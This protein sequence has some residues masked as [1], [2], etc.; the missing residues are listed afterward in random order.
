MI[1]KFSRQNLAIAM[2]D[3]IWRLQRPCRTVRRRT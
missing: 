2:I 1:S 3:W